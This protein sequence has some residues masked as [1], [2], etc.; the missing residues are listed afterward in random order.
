MAP[1]GPFNILIKFYFKTQAS[2]TNGKWDKICI[3]KHAFMRIVNWIMELR[4]NHAFVDDLNEIVWN[5]IDNWIIKAYVNN[6]CAFMNDVNGEWVKYR[7]YYEAMEDMRQW[8]GLHLNKNNNN[9]NF[10][11]KNNVK[12]W[13][14]HIRITQ[15]AFS[16]FY[17]QACV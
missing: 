2:M 16:T 10:R 3:L 4:I 5:K 14:D 1:F 7:W 8:I 17:I 12:Q 9:N 15:P 11:T 13:I 6:V